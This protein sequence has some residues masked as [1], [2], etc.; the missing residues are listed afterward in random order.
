MVQVLVSDTSPHFTLMIRTAQTYVHC[1][2]I[3]VKFFV[4]WI[5]GSLMML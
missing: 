4:A 1:I 3:S 2:W 5:G